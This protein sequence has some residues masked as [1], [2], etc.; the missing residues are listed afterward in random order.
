MNNYTEVIKMD[1]FFEYREKIIEIWNPTPSELESLEPFLETGNYIC[2]VWVYGGPK[3]VEDFSNI[4]SFRIMRP[5]YLGR[6]K[7]EAVAVYNEY[8]RI[9]GTFLDENKT[10]FK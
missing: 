4:S 8:K 3:E 7:E 1:K 6:T 9:F 10:Y 5:F 2:Y